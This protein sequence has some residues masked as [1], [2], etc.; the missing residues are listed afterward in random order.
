MLL[1][2]LARLAISV[3]IG[4]N[5]SAVTEV[6]LLITCSSLAYADRAAVTSK[7]TA[8]QL[9]RSVWPLR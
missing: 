9:I 5:W 1:H 7:E 6:L 4:R 2:G 3:M 8:A